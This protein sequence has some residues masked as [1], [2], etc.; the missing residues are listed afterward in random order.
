MKAAESHLKATEQSAA[1]E[2]K[3]MED[4]DDELIAN[5][6]GTDVIGKLG[7]EMELV[8]VEHIFGG[9]RIVVYYLA[10][11]TALEVFRQW[12]AAQGGDPGVADDPHALP[13]AP[14]AVAS[15]SPV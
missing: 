10:D 8:D 7:L 3:A 6:R 4:W 15:Y 5:Y 1:A 14:C 13:L 12:V 11:G 2:K 9:E